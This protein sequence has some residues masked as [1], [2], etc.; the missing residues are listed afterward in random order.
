MPIP[1]RWGHGSVGGGAG[2]R[3][4]PAAQSRADPRMHPCWGASKGA[5][6][7]G[8]RSAPRARPAPAGPA[9][10]LRHYSGMT[11]DGCAREPVSEPEAI[12]ERLTLGTD[13]PALIWRATGDGR[14][15]PAVVTLHGGGQSKTVVGPATV[16]RVV[17]AG[18]TL[19]AV[20][21]Y[22]H[23]DHVDE[24]ASS[25]DVSYAT[26]LE[27]VVHT[28]Q[29]LQRV[30]ADLKKDPAIKPNSI[31]VRGE[32]LGAYAA[33]TALGLG[34]PFCLGYRL[35]V[36]RITR[37]RSHTRF[38]PRERRMKKSPENGRGSANGFA[39]S[40]RSCAWSRSHHGRS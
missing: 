23:G 39:S 8:A 32:S 15:R 13:M 33:L 7:R 29:E 10:R 34:V 20:D 27:I 26:M 17:S 16:K 37:R 6:R 14:P 18:V 40:T 4:P 25:L 9:S 3:I 38:V 11:P 21:M 1:T 12:P 31:A 5:A 24:A 28:A 2:T 35:R 36:R 22:L 19:V 30:V